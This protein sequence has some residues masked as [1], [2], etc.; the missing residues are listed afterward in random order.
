MPNFQP[1]GALAGHMAQPQYYDPYTDM[2]YTTKTDQNIELAFT[3][4][5][6]ILLGTSLILCLIVMWYVDD[7][8]NL[9]FTSMYDWGNKD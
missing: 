6:S 9:S 8:G 3:I 2:G 4:I 7:D 1:Q 5:G